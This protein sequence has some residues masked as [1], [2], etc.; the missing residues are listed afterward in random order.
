[1]AQI[2]LGFKGKVSNCA[3]RHKLETHL[4]LFIA[5][6]WMMP[7]ERTLYIKV[8]LFLIIKYLNIDTLSNYLHKCNNS[9]LFSFKV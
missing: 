9:I 5:V 3:K 2:R 8:I 4:S 1:M 7:A 6:K